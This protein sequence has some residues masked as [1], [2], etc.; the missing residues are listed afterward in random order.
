VK[1]WLSA[2]P[3]DPEVLERQLLREP[4]DAFGVRWDEISGPVGGA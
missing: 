3:P 1:E 2:S 4:D